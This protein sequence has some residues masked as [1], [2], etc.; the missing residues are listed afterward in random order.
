MTSGRFRDAATAISAQ[1]SSLAEATLALD[2]AMR[3]AY[4]E[5]YGK[6]GR[7][8]YLRDTAYHLSF[9]ADAVGTNCPPLFT[10]Y[11]GWAKVLLTQVGIPTEDFAENLRCL[12]R[13]LPQ[14]LPAE[15]AA[16]GCTFV[17]AGLCNCR[18]SPTSCRP[19]WRNPPLWRPLASAYLEALL[20]G[21]RQNAS[22]LILDAVH[23]GTAIKDIYLQVFQMQPVRDRPPLAD[24]HD[25]GGTGTLLLGRDAIDH[26]VALPTNLRHEKDRAN[27]RRGVRTR[28]SARD[29]NSNRVRLLRARRVGYHLSRC[30]HSDFRH[31]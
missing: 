6:R 23:S 16:I 11:I 13:V 17:A 1:S 19:A 26:V 24:E 18:D 31:P 27:A 28:R 21:D 8:K 9:L 30:E 3:P 12:Q 15:L 10:D 2:Y 5:R 20:R 25:H 14:F 4:L 29:W 7:D 22:Q